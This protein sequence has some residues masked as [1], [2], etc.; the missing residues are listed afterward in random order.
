MKK[1][2]TL[3]FAMLMVTLI[4]G[5]TLEIGDGT[6]TQ[7]FPLGSYWGYERSAAVYTDSELG[8]QNLRISS[9][10]WYST[11]AVTVSVPTKI[12]LKTTSSTTLSSDTWANMIS[13]ATLVYDATHNSTVT[14]GWNEFSLISTF[15]VD[16]GSGVL[17]LVE[18]NYGGGGSGTSSGA[19][20]RY[21]SVTNTHETWTADNTPPTT[22]G[23]LSSYRPNI[24]LTYTT[25]TLSNPPNPAT[26]PSP[27]NAAT[28]VQKNV[29]LSWSSGG[30]SPTDYKI[31]WGTSETSFE[32]EQSGITTTSFS[33]PNLEYTRTYYW[34]VDP[35]NDYGYASDIATLPVWSFTTMDDPTI[36]EFPHTE[37]FDGTAFP[38]VGW[39]HQIGS[40][41]T[42]WQRSTGSSNPTVSPYSGAGMLYYNSYSLSDGSNA[43]LFSPP[44]DAGNADMVYSTSFWMYRYKSS[45]SSYTDKVEI[46]SNTTPS[47]TGATLLG[48]I[49]RDYDQAPVET[50][51]G[52]YQYTFEIGPGAKNLTYY[53]VI[54]KAISDFGYNI[55]IDEISFI[56]VQ[57][58]NPPNP[59]I[60]PS[61]GNNA[62]SV[63]INTNLSW[64]SGGGAP[65]GYKIYLGKDAESMELIANQT[66]TVFDPAENLLFGSSYSWKVD[67]YNEYGCASDAGEIPVWNFSTVNGI[68]ISP[69]PYNGATNQDATNLV[70]NWADVAGASSYKVKAG[71]SSGASDLVNMASVTESQYT[72][73][74]NWPY[75]TTIYWTVFTLNGTQEIQGTEW[76]FTTAADPTRSIPYLEDFNASTSLP[77]NWTG[78]FSVSSSHGVSS[79]GLYKNLWSSSTSAYVTT[80][81]VGPLTDNTTLQ[82]DYRYVEYSGYPNTAHTLVAGDKLEIQISTDGTTFTTIHTIDSSNHTTSTSFATC[83]VPITQAKVSQGDIIKAK[84]LATWGGGDYYLDIDNVY[85]RHISAEPVF[86]VTPESKAFGE[87]QINTVSS[88]QVFTIKND[89]GGTLTIDPAI[90]LIGTNVDQFLLTDTNSYPCELGSDETMTVSVTFAPTSIGE[91]TA[92]LKIVDNLSKTEHNIP[93]TGTG[94]DYSISSIP[95]L[96]D[97]QSNINGWTVLDVNDDGNEWE[98]L[99]ES[100]SNMAMQ[101]SYNYYEAMDDWF[102][103]P[104]INLTKDITYNIRYEYRV[105]VYYSSEN[106]GVYIGSSP[107]PADL[108]TLLDDQSPLTNEEFEIGTASFT[109]TATG[110]YYIG[111]YGYSDAN[112]YNL[113]VDNFR[114]TL[115]G[116][117]IVSGITSGGTANPDPAPI[118]NPVTGNPLDTS[119]TI[120]GITGTP[121]ITVITE[122]APPAVQLPNVGLSFVLSGTNFSGTTITINHNLGFVP[123]QI[124]YRIEPGT[125]NILTAG[126]Q[127][128]DLWNDTS[129]TFNLPSTKSAGD[130][131]IV[132]PQQEGQTLPVTLSN[133]AA[134]VT[135]EN[136]V[137]I[138]WLAE[139]ETN[140]SGYNIF[141]NEAKDLENAI[142]INAQLI[143][144]GTAAGTQISYFYT[145]FEV[146]T[147]QVYYYWLESIALDGTNE[148]YGPLTVTIGDPTQE[149]LPPVVPMVTKLYNAFPNPFNPNTNIRYS[150]KEAGKVKIEIYNMKGQKIKSYNQ[151]HSSPGYYQISWDG[152]DENGRNVASGIYLYRLTTANYTSAKKMVLAK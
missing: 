152:R 74:A 101:I 68:A 97:F 39:T 35:H 2:I 10:S 90:E 28:N 86:S 77:A 45:Y 135:S 91:K 54:F 11:T 117:D 107:T 146:Y 104:P 69:S 52:W 75:T 19:G 145:D 46:Y 124:A 132:F 32:N 49:I 149:P 33:P 144:Q 73:P 53:Y 3:C 65:T 7:R 118:Y 15:D 89:G 58:G 103:T 34:K 55:N 115:A 106:L 23:T 134:V 151:E 51:N 136:F 18:R 81:P 72:H 61:P 50:G 130:L 70:L 84:F 143:D 16:N 80:P 108:T 119:L 9:I 25:Y 78:T 26:N 62:T 41:T 105:D 113:Y 82:F 57:G 76:S 79:N 96:N 29:T 47:L 99:D 95:Y 4:F 138:A 66:E 133:F 5:D 38:P 83:S 141:R 140:H 87:L 92:Y 42:G 12:Y 98:R 128:V 121:V 59:A 88:A 63:A 43:S 44:I 139:T 24:T 137:N 21:T 109:P 37:S 8:S 116:S 71:T 129:V 13:G 102:I 126:S 48:T 150:L 122:W 125:W 93:L 6:S 14:G 31:F 56:R 64:S 36:T 142:K 110:I 94:A 100:G 147:N 60:N 127:G 111:F 67:P 85:F 123:E 148:F 120:E 114:I 17:V 131:G 1:V 30:G 27:A 40:G 22:S 112:M 20:I